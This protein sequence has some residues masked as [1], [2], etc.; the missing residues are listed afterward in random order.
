MVKTDKQN[1]RASTLWQNP[2]RRIR[3]SQLIL[4]STVPFIIY[5][6]I[7]SVGYQSALRFIL[8]G[9]GTTILV[10]ILAYLAASILGITLAGLLLLKLAEK[11]LLRFLIAG[12]LLAL[13]S[14]FFFT[15]PLQDYTLVGSLEGRVA[16]I[17][18]TPD[19]VAD[20]IKARSFGEAETVPVEGEVAEQ[21]PVQVRGVDSAETALSR[22]QEGVVTGA[23]VPTNQ[24]PADLPR[25]WQTT[26]LPDSARNPAILLLTFGIFLLL[27]TF[28]GWNSGHHPLAVFAELYVDL[29]RGIPMLVII[30]YVGFPIIGAIRD[31][32]GGTIDI[33][34]LVR[35]V[36]G[37]S[38]GYAAYMA[39]IFRAG[40]QAIPKGQYEASRSLGLTGWQTAR[41]IILPQALKIVIPPLGNEFIA[42]VKDT[43]LLSVLSV[44]DITQRAREFSSAT[45]QTFP[46]FN[47]VAVLYIVLTLAA[48]S[49]V[50]FVER[51]T[52]TAKR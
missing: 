10:A 22:L 39:E 40:I 11:T 32:T 14:I 21:R 1:K 13:A 38:L 50:K 6:F 19:R 7:S 44:R 49:L 12:L 31:A 45:F 3:P 8:P 15:R 51:R 36:V 18:G 35:G 27:L 20:Q 29:M 26:F 17:N 41:F 23:F 42:M 4:L 37:I 16:I 30:L 43:S 52:D 25:L 5:L 33:P 46:P 28:G 24:A 48:S 47:T 34:L 9:I 2:L